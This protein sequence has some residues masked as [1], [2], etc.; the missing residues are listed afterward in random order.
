MWGE[1]RFRLL[2][3]EKIYLR[4]PVFLFWIHFFVVNSADEY[5]FSLRKYPVN[6]E[7]REVVYFSFTVAFSFFLSIDFGRSNDLVYF[8]P[9]LFQKPLTK[10]C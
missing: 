7:V 2:R 3:E 6:Y 8:L 5:T 10:S 1:F 4:L 9:C